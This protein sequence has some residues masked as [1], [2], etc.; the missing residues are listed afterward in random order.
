MTRAEAALAVQQLVYTAQAV[1][2]ERLPVTFLLE[3]R[4]AATLLGEPT[5][6]PVAA[7][8]ADDVLSSV[9]VISPANGE[10]VTSPFTVRGN[11][12]AFEANVQWELRRGSAVIR[13]GF[14]TAA[15]CCTLSPYSFTVEAPPGDYSLVVHDED[16][17]D[18]EG[19]PPTQDT[20]RLTIR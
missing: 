13:R 15:E 11:A 12:A 14:A 2:H 8:A 9:S 17:S 3:G 10:T 19:N 7:A 16:V 4:P 18:G 20:K 5:D 6:R 1:A